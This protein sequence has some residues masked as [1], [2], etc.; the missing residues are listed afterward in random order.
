MTFRAPT[1]VHV[2]ATKIVL[3]LVIIADT[4]SVAATD[5]LTWHNDLARTGQNL[6]ETVL[7]PANVNSTN[8]GKLFLVSVDGQVYAQPLVVSTERNSVYAFDANDGTFLW[9][10]SIMA[11]GET[12]YPGCLDGTLTPEIEITATPVIGGTI[13]PAR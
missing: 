1:W 9:Q 6:T 8:F 11:P 7:T 10:K 5:V 3:T 2:C 13:R 12:P 4:R